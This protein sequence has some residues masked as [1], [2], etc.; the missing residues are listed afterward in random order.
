MLFQ[1][2]STNTHA[3]IQSLEKVVTR[4][5]VK[6]I[7]FMETIC[8]AVNIISRYQLKWVVERPEFLTLLISSYWTQGTEVLYIQNAGSQ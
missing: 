3:Q 4:P 5:R 6:Y 2:W 8:K 1:V 7:I